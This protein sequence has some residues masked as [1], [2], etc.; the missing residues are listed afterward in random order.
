MKKTGLDV[1]GFP[2]LEGKWGNDPF[3]LRNGTVVLH[4]GKAFYNLTMHCPG[5]R[6]LLVAGSKPMLL[7]YNCS[8]LPEKNVKF[9]ELAIRLV[10]NGKSGKWLHEFDDITTTYDVGRVHYA[11]KDRR[12]RGLLLHLDIVP[13]VN[14]EGALV[15]VWG[16]RP[17]TGKA[18]VEIAWSYGGMAFC[19]S[20]YN[21]W[22]PGRERLSPKAADCRFNRVAI[23]D[24][25]FYLTR[26][27]IKSAV[28]HG[29]ASY[30][31]VY[32][33]N[34]AITGKKGYPVVSHRARIFSDGTSQFEGYIAIAWGKDRS[35]EL[36][37]KHLIN[38]A[39]E[40]YEA[41]LDY[42]QNSA[43]SIRVKTPD[44]LLDAGIK[45]A[46]YSADAC[47]RPPAF[48]HSSSTWDAWYTGWRDLYGP[49]VAGWHNRVRST[50]LFESL[51]TSAPDKIP[52]EAKMNRW[53]N[54][55]IDPSRKATGRIHMSTSPMTNE[56]GG[57]HDCDQL[58]VDFAYQHFCWTGDK[59]LIR[60]L[61]PALSQ[62]MEFQRITR[63]PDE[64]GLYVNVLNT[65]ISDSHE[66][67]QG[68]CTVQ[69]AY[70]WKNNLEMAE[71]ARFL[72]KD[73]RPYEQ[74]AA[75]IK[76]AMMKEL[77]LKDLGVFA[78]YRDVIGQIHPSP[79]STSLYHPIEFGL[80]DMF[81]SYEM[82]QF[83]R[84]RMLLPSGLVVSSLWLPA[85]RCCHNTP[86]VSE[87]LNMALASF[88]VSQNE[89]AL[90][91]LKGC[92]DVYDKQA[93]VRTNIYIPLNAQSD[94]GDVDM[95]DNASLFQRTFVEGL[96]GIR[97]EMQFKRINVTPNFPSAWTRAG[98]ETP[99]ISYTFKRS[100][101]EIQVR[102][103]T[104]QAVQKKLRLPLKSE[105][106]LQV[107]VNGARTPFTCLP[108]MGHYYLEVNV[109][110]GSRE[111]NV[112]VRFRHSPIGLS[113]QE[114]Y[115]PNDQIRIK[116]NHCQ[117]LEF[118]D[119]HACAT[120]AAI[121]GDKTILT[122]RLRCHPG[123]QVVFV[124]IRS[125]NRVLYEPVEFEVSNPLEILPGEIQV[126]KGQLVYS[127]D[128]INNTRNA[129][130]ADLVLILNNQQDH[131]KCTLPA[132]GKS[133]A[134]FRLA[135]N[136]ARRLSPG[137]NTIDISGSPGHL[138]NFV[139]IVDW[140]MVPRFPKL[141][142][143][144]RKRS[145]FLTLDRK[146][147]G[148]MSEILVR[149][150]PEVTY[151]FHVPKERKLDDS[152]FRTKI[153]RGIF[154]SDAGIQFHLARGRNDAVYIASK[155]QKN[156][157]SQGCFLITGRAQKFYAASYPDSVKIP[158]GLKGIEKTYLMFLG[159]TSWMQSDVPAVRITL[160][161]DKGKNDVV[162]YSNPESFDYFLEHASCHFA[163]PLTK[164]V[165]P[166]QY[167]E[168][169]GHKRQE[170][171]DIADIRVDPDRKLEFIQLSVV[172]LDTTMALLGLTLLREAGR[173]GENK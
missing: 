70:L 145:L 127:I 158:I 68:A 35:V 95:L 8:V 91:M 129:Q 98:I 100:A 161:Y 157:F 136:V 126:Q 5:S 36:P 101:N 109:P 48:L 10:V 19:P 9:G 152:Y 111:D 81:Q 37:V 6:T 138:R 110:E 24:G 28:V 21:P 159:A 153:H 49:T 39:E 116:G 76:K 73:S 59:E 164:R 64:D 57:H 31:G 87:T 103:K 134:T 90:K 162:E 140:Q 120:H 60:D 69:S 34:E 67:H 83:V 135:A 89:L 27:D 75:K 112:V 167:S 14:A 131:L 1:S 165:E 51:H 80:P 46:N 65:W 169:T 139:D 33:V 92:F 137:K 148:R 56:T 71:M 170:H 85:G 115:A 154:T 40:E 54:G 30:S 119:P 147:N 168:V 105:E 25:G 128:L 38:K 84:D 151:G 122:G 124:K 93:V 13:L 150:P 123:K 102:L 96:F 172:A 171:A 62:A 146:C 53:E 144:L 132:A 114:Q 63:D 88:F 121:S 18:T 15:K 26:K 47:W 55:Y 141:S 45:F 94:C 125:E 160:G 42:S 99:D 113:C 77:W 11:L 61:W 41:S 66:Y 86:F 32:R 74:E 23:E 12:F 82:L 108:G 58:F 52:R 72:G 155:P 79:E 163:Q 143:E 2:M 43:N 4:N 118:I 50:L 20:G 117:I 16:E 44:P 149:T 156:L 104:A 130:R 142:S 97:P 133:R 29:A 22:D 7:L 78:E 106:V 107:A 17:T 166:W 173:A 3:T